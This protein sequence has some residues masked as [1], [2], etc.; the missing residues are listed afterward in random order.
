MASLV[1]RWLRPLLFLS[2]N[3]ISRAGLLLVLSA[4][5]LWIFLT[6]ASAASGYLGILQFVALPAMFFAG[7][8]L[9]PLGIS[10]AK[11]KLAPD[12][13]L[14]LPE[15]IELA[16]PK[17]RNF[18]VFVAVATGVNLVI[19]GS[20]SYSAVHYMESNNFCGTACHQVMGPEFRAYAAGNH[21]NVKC[22]AC[23]V[24]EGAGNMVKAKLNGTRQLLM[25]MTGGYSRPIPAPFHGL[26]DAQETCLNCH[27]STHDF[28]ERLWRTAKFNDGGER[29]DTVMLMKLGGGST[30]KG[31]H[32]AHLAPDVSIEYDAADDK[33]TKIVRV[34]YRKGNDLREYSMAGATAMTRKMDCL[35][36]HNRPAHAMKTAERAVDDAFLEGRLS[37]AVP[38]LRSAAL[39]VLRQSYASSSEATG[40]IPER[41]KAYFAKNDAAALGAHAGEIEKAGSVLKEL[42][43]TNVSPEMKLTWGTYPSHI[44]HTE[45][46]GCFRCHGDEL[47]TKTG[48][49]IT[50]DCE[51]C[52]KALA[53]EEKNPKVFKE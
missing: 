27:Q 47:K 43:A 31:I 17:V 12:H 11:R 3:W 36:C 5:V 7:L 23:H 44:G 14:H 13:Q 32:G 46:P 2:D 34:R 28:G 38:K 16:N 51:A 50:Q 19:G 40:A 48:Q 20:L 37:T 35:D 25:V 29:L 41:L 39:D 9:I 24:G 52:H 26:K 30:G 6:G 49:T 21:T 53:V 18:L 45:S 10:L 8:V 42:F 4:T 22:V 15:K 33:R 1:N